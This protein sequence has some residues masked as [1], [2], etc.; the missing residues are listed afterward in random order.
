MKRRNKDLSEG[1]IK[2][3]LFNL[4]W[5]MLFG[6]AGM[7]IFNLA[8]TYFIG[9][10]G[11][12]ELA[13][14]S[15]TFPVVMF[16][17]SLSQGIG[18]GT[19]S[20]ISRHIIVAERHAVKMM[21]SRALLLGFLIVLLFVIPGL[22][23]IRPLFTVLGAK[24]IILG[25]V[26]DYM[27]IWY[28][29]V[30]F[31]VFPMIGNNIVRATGDTF[32]PGML[33]LNSAIIN[34]ILD[35]L[36][37]FGYGFFPRMG[38]RGAALATVIARSVSFVFILIILIRREK[39]LTVRLGRLREILATWK[40]V[41]YVA[42]PASLGMLITPLSIGLITRILS[43]FGKEAVAAFGVASRVEMF[44][45]T[46]IAALGSV[47]I[48]FIGQNYSKHKFNRIFSALRY[49]LGFSMIWGILI[50][51]ILL[52]FGR[53]IAGIFTDDP[54][55]IAIAASFFFIVGSSYGFQGLV[56]LSTSSYNGLNR[57]Y[58]AVFFSMLRML[59]L[60]VP[61][62]WIGATFYALK[63]VFWAGFTANIIAGTL[64]Y[65]FLYHCVKRI[66]RQIDG[67]CF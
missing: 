29:G 38:I 36:L 46:V 27:K 31:V 64:S 17:N 66:E 16:I 39:L 25:Y 60:Y 42:G 15:F 49:A 19:S 48:I 52:L 51:L 26:G 61:L 24:N 33:M 22:F 9:R 65:A 35:P 54:R 7:V 11:V 47:L 50:F 4:V 6:M 3:Q 55:V 44:A 53:N 43:G 14:I 12:Q 1:N 56:M 13:A 23:T 40:K 63:G 58:P 30:P 37:I 59:F 57:P 8:D 28:L 45:L 2:K 41:L 32:M 34:V 10:L 18:I 20:L 62:A 21:A 5:P 67:S